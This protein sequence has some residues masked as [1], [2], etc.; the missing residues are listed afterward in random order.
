MERILI[1][2]ASRGIGR[3]IAIRLAA[4]GR[5]LL[6]HG[7]DAAALAE[8]GRRIEEAGAKATVQLADLAVPEQVRA[9]AAAVGNG[10]LHV[11]VNNAGGAVV[12]PVEAITAA[13]WE[14]SLAVTVTA[15][16][17]LV[18]RLLPFLP[19]GACIVNVLSIAA[20]RGFAGWSTYC[21]AKAALEG[22]SRSLREELRPRGVR[23][24]NV[25]PA[26]TNTKLWDSVPGTWERKRMLPPEE[27]AEAVA[28]AL[29]RPPGVVVET[30]EVG[31]VSGPL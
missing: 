20:R 2:G 10:P 3:A 25:F 30:V 28:Y 21:T 24:V 6:L 31:D 16:F 29:S 1:T 26:A 7:R 9:L 18:Q 19:P 12:G 14:T 4:P 15:P 22:F 5:E 11:L 23:V 13:E 8:V 27:V 17:L